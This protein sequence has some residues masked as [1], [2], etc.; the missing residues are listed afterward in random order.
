MVRQLFATGVLKSAFWHLFT[1]TAHSPVGLAPENYKVKKVSETIGSFANNDI[2]H[3]DA[4][5]ANHEIFGYGLKKAILNY[6][7]GACFEFPLQKWFEF[8]IPK[9]SIAPNYIQTQLDAVEIGLN[10]YKAIWTGLMPTTTIVQRAKK[11]SKW[12]EM[13]LRFETNKN[14]ISIQVD[15]DKGKWFMQLLSTIHVD[16]SNGMPLADI[17]T[18]Y[19]ASGLEDFDLF[20]DNKP[21]NTL[22]K[23]GLLRI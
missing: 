21:I 22:H 20:W 7:H 6:M 17:K 14:T 15:P 23:A 5:G 2:V 19:V 3:I 11:G 9:T 12:A 8:K 18:N 1:M 13:N 16:A 4:S 10:N